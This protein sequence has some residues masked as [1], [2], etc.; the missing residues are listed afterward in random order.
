MSAENQIIKKQNNDKTGVNVCLVGRQARTPVGHKSQ[1]IHNIDMKRIILVLFLI[2]PI[3]S[4]S[5]IPD[6]IKMNAD[7][8]LIENTSVEIYNK[9]F[10]YNCVESSTIMNHTY[11]HNC[12]SL[13]KKQKRLF[14]KE[15]RKW[16]NKSFEI[17]Y[18]I[19]LLDTIYA[20][21]KIRLDENGNLIRLDGI[22]KKENIN[23]LFELTIDRKQ[24]MEIALKNGFQKGLKPWEVYVVFELNEEG[25]GV[26][27]WK[28]TNT[29]VLDESGRRERGLSGEIL[30]LNMINGS[31]VEK[32][33]WEAG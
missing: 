33:I 7:S 6:F 4:Y 11:W 8:I 25:K 31:V 5:Q 29:L 9:V 23:L 16:N 20:F 19:L 24:A 18:D 17:V 10:K 30:Y 22:P 21:V 12:D 27:K 26:Y 32:L 3:L 28:I 1:N 13:T 15:S 2:V 14:R